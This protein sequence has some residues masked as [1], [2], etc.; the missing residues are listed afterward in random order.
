VPATPVN[1]PVDTAVATLTTAVDTTAAPVVSATHHTVATLPAK[2]VPVVASTI[3]Q[4]TAPAVSTVVKA[5]Q[6][7]VASAPEVVQARMSS[8]SHPA[9]HRAVAAHAIARP[10]PTQ[11]RRHVVRQLQAAVRHTPS[12]TFR[13]APVAKPAPTV[14]APRS[15]A[16]ASEPSALLPGGDGAGSGSFAG[17]LL[18]PGAGVPAAALTTLAPAVVPAGAKVFPPESLLGRGFRPLLVLERPD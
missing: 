4:T 13:I 16:R 18:V 17:S 10:K 14:S 6:P 8:V 1:A 15:A 5:A 12:R 7:A 9:V 2:P 3:S 11:P